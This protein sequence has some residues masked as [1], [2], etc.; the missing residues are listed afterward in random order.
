[1]TVGDRQGVS[2]ARG[3]GSSS[4]SQVSPALGPACLSVLR[5][6]VYCLAQGDLSPAA[7]VWHSRQITRQSFLGHFVSP[8]P[9]RA[10]RIPGSAPHPLVADLSFHLQS[11]LKCLLSWIPGRLHLVFSVLVKLLISFMF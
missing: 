5:A 4:S 7:S 1:M 3:F 8:P 10:R 9:A 2:S 11:N 6:Y